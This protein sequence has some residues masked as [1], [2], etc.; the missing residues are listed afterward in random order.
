MEKELR[1]RFKVNYFHTFI[2]KYLVLVV[3]KAECHRHR[4]KMI[5][6]TVFV[7]G[8]FV[9]WETCIQKEEGPVWIPEELHIQPTIT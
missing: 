7:P 8:L 1:K 5:F 6:F 3:D 9:Q 2:P 4:G